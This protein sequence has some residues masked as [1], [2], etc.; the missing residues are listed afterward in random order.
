MDISRQQFK[1]WRS[2]NKSSTV[3]LF[4]VW[5]ASRESYK[6]E[7]RQQTDEFNR[8]QMKQGVRYARNYLIS[9]Y[10]ANFINCDQKTFAEFM[11]LLSQIANE[12]I[13]TELMMGD[14]LAC[15]QQAED[16][17]KSILS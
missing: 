11:A 12:S 8:E 9:A 17:I 10:R 5:Q 7:I 14:V 4:D 3:D 13:D 16:W 15:N 2:G 6:Q 1:E